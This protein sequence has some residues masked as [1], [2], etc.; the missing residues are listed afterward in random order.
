[1]VVQS[2]PPGDHNTPC[3]DG[4][5]LGAADPLVGSILTDDLI[6]LFGDEIAASRPSGALSPRPWSLN[7]ALAIVLGQP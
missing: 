4:R 3:F 6:P 7:K 1:M 2:S 5:P